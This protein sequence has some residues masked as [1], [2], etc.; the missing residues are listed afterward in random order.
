[1]RFSQQPRAEAIDA[2]CKKDCSFAICRQAGDVADD[3]YMAHDGQSVAFE[4]ASDNN[5]Q[6]GFVVAPYYHQDK[7][8]FIKEERDALPSPD[9]FEDLPLQQSLAQTS[10]PTRD[11]YSKSFQQYVTSLK[12]GKLE[13]LVLARCEDVGTPQFS[14][15]RAY[16]RACELYPNAFCALF[17]S[18]ESGTWICSTPEQLIKGDGNS[19]TSMSLAGTQKSNSEWS[20]KNKREQECVSKHT[21]DILLKLQLSA[22]EDATCTLNSGEIE[23]LCTIFHIEM[24]AHELG[25]FLHGFPPTPAVC[26][27]PATEA[28][29]YQQEHPDIERGYYAG[30]IGP[31]RPEGETSIYVTLRCMQVLIDRCRLYAGGGILPESEEEA[32][33]QETCLKMQAMRTLLTEQVPLGAN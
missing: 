27:Y 11:D 3:F 18:P 32:E 17:H 13:K 20:A 6:A 31:Y 2:L 8:S 24:Q 15:A 7:L 4:L 12:A 22:R 25:R 19:W 16:A 23:H 30:F 10:C 14:P 28:R 9:L 21:R 26:G 1:M 5:K 33:W 29:A